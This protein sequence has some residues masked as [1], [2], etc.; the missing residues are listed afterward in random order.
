[1]RRARKRYTEAWRFDIA[2]SVGISKIP[3]SVHNQIGCPSA[4]F[5]MCRDHTTDYF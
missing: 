2:C 3:Y 1:M 5:V 4:S